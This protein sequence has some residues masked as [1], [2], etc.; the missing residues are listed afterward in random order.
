MIPQYELR[1]QYPPATCLGEQLTLLCENI[2]SLIGN[3]TWYASDVETS[4]NTFVDE[5]F[6]SPFPKKIGNTYDIIKLAKSVQ[7]FLSGVFLLVKDDVGSQ[8]NEEYYT[9]DEPFRD[10]RN[11]HL[12]IRA[13]DTSFFLIYSND[14]EIMNKLSQCT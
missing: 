4:N 14:L 5:N 6:M 10:L 1:I 9:E 12:E 8:I 7:Q 2:S 3:E 13:F 11:A